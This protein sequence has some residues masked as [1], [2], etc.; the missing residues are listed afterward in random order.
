MRARQAG[1]ETRNVGYDFNPN[2]DSPLP[3]THMS[4]AWYTDPNPPSPS[5]FLLLLHLPCLGAG[6]GRAGGR[7]PGMGP[8]ETAPGTGAGL[9]AVMEWGRGGAD[10][11]ATADMCDGITLDSNDVDRPS[12]SGPD[13]ARLPSK[14]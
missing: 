13:L 5:C 11:D 7:L 2:P 6:R 10:T 14:A 12:P 9:G 3:F 8:T 1:K 4:Y